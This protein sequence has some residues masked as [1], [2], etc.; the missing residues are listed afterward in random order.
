M[1]PRAS[2]QHA[3]EE[4]PIVIHRPLLVIGYGEDEGEAED[5]EEGE[6]D[7]QGV[8]NIVERDN[9]EVEN[10][11]EV[12]HEEVEQEVAGEEQQRAEQEGGGGVARGEEGGVRRERAAARV[13][14]PGVG[15]VQQQEDDDVNEEGDH[16]GEV[17][18][19]REAEVG[20]RLDLGPCAEIEVPGPTRLPATADGFGDIDALGAWECGLC[21]FR[22][23]EEVPLPLREKFSKIVAK[24]L[25]KHQQASSDAEETRALKWFLILPQ[26]LLREAKRGGASTV[27]QSQG[28][29]KI[30]K[31]GPNG[32]PV[33]SKMGTKWGPF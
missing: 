11:V 23:L 2:A 22:T 32:D 18:D 8:E 27:P 20:N 21:P 12:R 29:P 17:L 10:R 3:A 31:R 26:L 14:Q 6:D 1:S 33:L 19:A 13:P 25:L 9:Q 4:A 15:G 28:D 16:E 7:E 5:D 30:V 24:I